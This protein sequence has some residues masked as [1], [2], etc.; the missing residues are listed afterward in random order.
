MPALATDGATLASG[1]PPRNDGGMTA[2][3][4]SAPRPS[5]TTRIALVALVVLGLV[6]VAIAVRVESTS[7]PSGW[8]AYAPMSDTTYVPASAYTLRAPALLTGAGA[9]L[10]GGAAGFAVGRRRRPTA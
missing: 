8:F 1:G 6:L 3:Q 9:L 2:D 5:S 10:L 7:V 4:P